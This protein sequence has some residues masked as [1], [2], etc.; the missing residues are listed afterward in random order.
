MKEE[1][2]TVCCGYIKDG[3]RHKCDKIKKDGKW[4]KGKRTGKVS[5]GMCLDCLKE[6]QKQCQDYIEE[7]GNE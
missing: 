6:F 2:E 5:H 7:K 4:V 1:L 3:K